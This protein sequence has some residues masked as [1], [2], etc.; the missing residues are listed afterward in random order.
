[1]EKL[2]CS[3]SGIGWPPLPTYGEVTVYKI[4]TYNCLCMTYCKRGKIRW[5]TLLRFSRCSEVQRKFC[6]EYKHISLII[7]NNEHLWP[8]QRESISVKT[9]MGLKRRAFS[10]ANLSPSTVSLSKGNKTV[11]SEIIISGALWCTWPC[12]TCRAQ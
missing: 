8:R 5:A 3:S 12:P 9:L 7:Q 4:I 6:H 11:F 1:M 2:T 10:P